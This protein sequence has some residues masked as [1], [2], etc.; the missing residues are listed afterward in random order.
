MKTKSHFDAIERAKSKYKELQVKVARAEKVFTSSLGDAFVKYE[1]EI[2]KELQRG[3]IGNDWY[4]KQLMYLSNA[5][6]HYFG[7]SKKVNDI[8]DAEIADF[9]DIRLK[10]CK[11]KDTVRQELTIVT[12]FNH[13]YSQYAMF[14]MSRCI[15]H[16]YSA[17]VHETNLAFVKH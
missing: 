5:F 2:K 13:L 9:V 6:I 4:K 17:K 11:R 14:Q 15:D 16:R 8:S 7:E 10:A 3:M 1:E 12:F